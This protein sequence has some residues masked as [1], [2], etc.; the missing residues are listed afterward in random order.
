[1]NGTTDFNEITAFGSRGHTRMMLMALNSVW[2]GRVRLRALVDDIENG[3]HDSDLDVPVISSDR[4]RSDYGDL[5]VLLAVGS[6]ALRERVSARL[7]AENATL[8]TVCCMGQPL[9]YPG[10]LCGAGT[11]ILPF[12]RLGPGIR[13]GHGAQLFC[14]MVAHDVT[15]G[16][17]VTIGAGTIVAGH[18]SIGDGVQ[19]GI[20]AMINNGSRD[21]PLVIGADAVIGSGAVIHQS[22]PPG[23][24][25]MGN[26]A[27]DLRDWVALRRLARGHRTSRPK[28]EGPP[29]GA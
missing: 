15:I 18:V 4:R 23:A 25:M 24:R 22:V 7:M 3:F 8:A 14:E 19:I 27:M 10:T 20:G 26:P 17:F 16:N 5:P 28:P 2:K 13:I 6:G 29:D 1:M 21:R 11:V 9:A 12:T